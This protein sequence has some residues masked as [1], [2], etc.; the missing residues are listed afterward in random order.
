MICTI[1]T[2]NEVVETIVAIQ[3]HNVPKDGLAANLNHGFGAEVAF[4]GDAGAQAAGEDDGFHDA[5][6]FL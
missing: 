6:S 3:F 5:H 4:F 1:S 2:D